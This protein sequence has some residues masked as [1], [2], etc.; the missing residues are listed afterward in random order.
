MPG[1]GSRRLARKGFLS[2]TQASAELARHTSTMSDPVRPVRAF[3]SPPHQELTLETPENVTDEGSDLRAFLALFRRH[4]V[5]IAVVTI[6]P[7]VIPYA[8]PSQQAAQ[9]SS[10][11]TLEFTEPPNAPA[12]ADPARDVSTIVGVGSSS[13]VLGPVAKKHGM[14]Q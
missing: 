12:N 1:R 14:T 5:L 8:F 6:L 3:P 9:Y 2:S 4:A 10:T 7:G 13:S 11:A